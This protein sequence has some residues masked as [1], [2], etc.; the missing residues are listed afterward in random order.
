MFHILLVALGGA[1][2]ASCRHLVGMASLKSFGPGYPWGT[3]IVNI[4][5]SA[6]IGALVELIARRFDASAELRLFAVTGFLGGFTTFS[7]FSLD[8]VNMIE[9]G[10]M[11]GAVLYIGSSVVLSVAA[12]FGGLALVRAFG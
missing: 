8:A 6:I 1:I 10:D 12:L 3:F 11:G 4:V 7:S 9:R 5:G 2:G